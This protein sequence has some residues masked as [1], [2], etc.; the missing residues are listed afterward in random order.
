[1][2]KLDALKL[3]MMTI[4]DNSKSFEFPALL[5]A[6]RSIFGIS[7]PEVARDL[8]VSDCLFFWL[9]KGCFKRPLKPELLSKIARYYGVPEKIITDKHNEFIESGK[10]IAPYERKTKKQQRPHRGNSGKSD[11]METSWWKKLAV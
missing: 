4:I 11:T 7:R 3:Q 5:E 2:Y 10:G 9:E 1:M 6:M 8:G